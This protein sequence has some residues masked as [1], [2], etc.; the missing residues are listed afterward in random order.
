[1]NERNDKEFRELIRENIAPVADA[2]LK[3]DL[4]PEMLRKL[5]ETGIRM[6]WFDWALVGLVAIWC[7]FFPSAV[8]GLLYHL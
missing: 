4:W 2:R 7:L 1:M 6:S 5:D 8:L 3:R